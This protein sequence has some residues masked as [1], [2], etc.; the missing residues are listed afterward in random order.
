MAELEFEGFSTDGETE[1]LVSEAD[2]E[3][4]GLSDELANVLVNVS[5]RGWIAGAV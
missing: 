3:D 2:T 1:H 4:R 5:K